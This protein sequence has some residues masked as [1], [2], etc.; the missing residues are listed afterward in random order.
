MIDGSGQEVFVADIGIKQGVIAEVGDL[1]KREALAEY[2]IAGLVVAPGFIDIHS[3]SELS[4]L[5]NPHVTSKLYQGVTTEVVGNCG[6]SVAPVLE[7][8]TES[9]SKKLAKYNLELQWEGV[10]EY[11]ATVKEQGSS[12]NLATLVGHSLLRQ[13]V[14]GD[15]VREPRAEEL[16]TMKKHLLVAMQEGAWGLST[17][18]IYP[19]SANANTAE[20]IELAKVVAE[21]GGIYATHL[22]DEG[23][24]LISAVKEAIEIAEQTGVSVQISHHK[25]NGKGNWGKVEQTLELI[26]KANQRGLNINCDVYPY[27]ATSTGLAALLPREFKQGGKEKVLARL[28]QKKNKQQLRTYWQQQRANQES[29]EQIIIAEVNQSQNKYLEGKSIAQIAAEKGEEAAEV[30]IELLLAERLAVS[31][32]KFS[33]CARDLERVMSYDGTMI[34]S[35]AAARAKDGLL[36]RSIPHPRAY[37]SFP[38]V[39]NSYVK[40]KEVLGLEEAVKKMSYLPAEKLG[41]VDRGRI[42]EGLVADLVVFDLDKFKDLATYEEPH[43]Y[44]QGIKHLLVNGQFVIKD[45][46]LEKRLPGQILTKKSYF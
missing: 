25:A 24:Q 9:I 15:Q 29:W 41:L 39:I 21:Q 27:L 4:I 6:S 13:A 2:N 23:D 46:T 28:R 3:H 1:Q 42:K 10:A 30:V 17:G 8:T 43:Q 14:L 20:L 37:G 5:A 36:D 18:L 16:A 40:E 35:D 44:A 31:M 7:Q 33:I 19:P 38:R 12:V 22:R 11:L 34:A 45:S 26:E 32:V